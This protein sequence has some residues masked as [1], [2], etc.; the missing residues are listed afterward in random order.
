MKRKALALIIAASMGM[1]ACS[2]SWVT[3]A[4]NITAVVAPAA[5]NV[6]TLVAAFQ[7]VPVNVQKT[8]TITQDIA[9]V[10]KLLTDYKNSSALAA[11][12]VLGQLNSGLAVTQSDLST[13]LSTAKVSDPTT[14]LKVNALVT[15]ILAEVQSVA[16]LIPENTQP[17]TA[18]VI[19]PLTSK[20]FKKS[21][22]AIMIGA[23]PTLVLK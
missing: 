20:Q 14:Q 17:K 3:E 8:A 16:S 21:F 2:T 12:T 10:S 23:N 15:F 19:I 6:L 9:N 18:R 5:I 22:N 11:P 13:I 7:G 1:T 4:L